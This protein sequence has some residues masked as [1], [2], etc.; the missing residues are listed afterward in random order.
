VPVNR[1]TLQRHID[2]IEKSYEF[3][4]AYAAQ[5]AVREEATKVGA[6]LRDFLGRMSDALAASEADIGSL[7]ETES[8]EPAGPYRD[9]LALTAADAARAGTAVRLVMSRPSISSELVDNLNASLHLRTLLTDLFLIDDALP[10]VG[11]D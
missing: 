5:G 3:F 6:Q 4:L 11:G 1:D 9:M 10:A 8:L 2:E 7:V